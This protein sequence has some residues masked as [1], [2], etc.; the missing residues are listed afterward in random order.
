VGKLVVDSGEVIWRVLGKGLAR[1]KGEA[2][3][4]ENPQSSA[5]Y[6]FSSE[7]V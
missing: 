3:A 4:P 1:K 6:D 5:Q 2:T 7:C